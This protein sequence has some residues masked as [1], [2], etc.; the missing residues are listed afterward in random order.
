M[1]QRAS[2][3]ARAGRSKRRRTF[4]AKVF[5]ARR[6]YSF[7]EIAEMLG[8]HP[9]TVQ[10]WHKE[11]LKILTDGVKPYLVMGRDIQDFLKDRIRKRKK[12]LQAG[13]FFC[14]RCQ[15]A[16]NSLAQHLQVEFTNRM[17]GPHHRQAIIRGICEVCGIRVSRFS[18]ELKAAQWYKNGLI[19]SEQPTVLNG[20]G[21]S[22]TNADISEENEHEQSKRKE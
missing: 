13:Q 3:A 6:A 20:S 14:T 8:I 10:T 18:S 11:G 7:V 21:D 1:S 12:P 16:R 2:S 4:S 9:Q 19:V 5:R 22:C 17:L 15:Q